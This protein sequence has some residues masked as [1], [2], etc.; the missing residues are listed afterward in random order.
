MPDEL[1]YSNYPSDRGKPGAYLSSR[2]GTPRA[3]LARIDFR[4]CLRT[5]IMGGSLWVLGESLHEL[6]W[7]RK[8]PEDLVARP[9]S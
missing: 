7:I 3:P 8:C 6:L 2:R 9:S 5:C 1:I 4:V